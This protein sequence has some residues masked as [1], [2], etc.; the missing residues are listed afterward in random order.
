MRNL[1]HFVF[2]QAEKS[3][4]VLNLNNDVYD[5]IYNVLHRPFNR[6]NDDPLKQRFDR[7]I[8]IS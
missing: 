4:I 5:N 2:V 8:K 3:E 6:F 7:L 1:Q